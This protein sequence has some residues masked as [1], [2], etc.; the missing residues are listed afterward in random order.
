MQTPSASH[1][2]RRSDHQASERLFSLWSIALFAV[3]IV[4]VLMVLFPK[5]RIF[6]Q[7]AQASQASTASTFFL[8]NLLKA[9][10]DDADLRL[11][12]ANH[13]LELGNI[14]LSEGTLSSLLNIDNADVWLRA[15]LLKVRILEIQ[16]FAFAE[17]S[18]KRRHGMNLIG[19]QIELI[20]D[21]IPAP[22]PDV[23]VRLA[24]S[25]LQVGHG[26]VAQSIY[27]QLGRG[28]TP[29]TATW[30]AKAAELALGQRDYQSAASFYFS[31]QQQE[32]S[33]SKQREYYLAALKTLQS[34]N[35][36]QEAVQQ[37]ELHLGDL[38]ND[39]ATLFFL[40]S[41]GRAAGNG[42][43]AQKYVKDLLHANL[44]HS[45][46]LMMHASFSQPR[47]QNG[48]DFVFAPVIGDVSESVMD[49]N[50]SS[51][52]GDAF[53]PFTL[54]DLQF[55]IQAGTQKQTKIRPFDDKIYQLGYAVFLENRNLLDAFTLAQ[56]AVRQVP[57]RMEWRKRLAQVA[58]WIG[59]HPLALAQWREIAEKS[60]S[61]EAFEQILRLAPAAYDDEQVIFAFLGLGKIRS[62]STAERKNLSD[63]FERMGRPEDA[64]A[65]LTRLHRASPEQALLE[66]LAVLTQRM[67]KDMQAMEYYQELE[68][69]YGSRL[70]W[71][72]QQARG[73]SSRGYLRGAYDM[74]LSVKEHAGDEDDE[75]WEFVGHLAWVFEDD[76]AA[77]EAYRYLWNRQQLSMEG[78][79]RLIIL[80]RRTNPDEAIRIGIAGWKLYQRPKFLLEALTLLLQERKIV[81]LQETFDELLPSDET[82][83]ASNPQYWVIRAEVMWKIGKKAEAYRAYEHALVLNPGSQETRE[84]FLWFLVDQKNITSLKKY[85]NLWRKDIQSHSRLWG[86]A[87]AAY[88]ALDQP[89]QSLPFFVRQ[90]K[91]QKNDYLWLLNYADALEASSRSALAWQ[92]RQYA[93]LVVRKAFFVQSSQV[94]SP[95]LFEA[96]ARLV[97]LKDPGDQLHLLLQNARTNTT[98]MMMK[99]LVL[100]WFL[101][102]EAFDAAKS[103]LW[104]NYAQQFR[105]P[106]WAKLAL[107]L[108]ENNWV[109]IESIV[110]NHGEDLSPSDK[111]EA[112]N[113]LERSP[114][115]QELA[116]ESL[117]LQSGNDETYFKYQE[118]IDSAVNQ[119]TSRVLF[120][121]RQP[122]SRYVWNTSVSVPVGRFL[123]KPTSSVAWQESV[124]AEELTGVPRVDQRFGISLDYRL[125]HGTI[126]M[127]GFHRNALSNFFGVGLDYEHTWNNNFSSKLTIGRN[128]KADDSILLLIGGVKDFIRGQGLYY[129]TKRQFV[130]LQ[131]DAPR[132][133]SQSR[134]KLGKGL[135][136]DGAIGHHIR[137]EYPDVTVRLL[138]TVQRYSR[139][140]SVPG[141][142]GRLIPSSQGETTP[143]MVVPESFAQTGINLSLGDSIRDLYTKG[144]R[145]FGLIGVNYN[146]ATG[147]GR[148]IEAGIAARVLG[149]DRLLVY[150]SN[151]RG[152]FGQNAT[153]S[154]MNLEYQRWF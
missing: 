44:L 76:Q 61:Q 33:Q 84:A 47:R 43:F 152:G 131:I 125:S 10:P 77:G 135:G 73:L 108:A 17:G 87:A 85:L 129:F 83:L 53:H 114:I 110:L 41:L 52:E 23:L 21:H 105:G 1:A 139:A 136:V 101:S 127:T 128:Y 143:I 93:W 141:S 86:P 96:Y 24:Q 63:A 119:M 70:V 19:S 107:A 16:T 69:R 89:K 94:S 25:A 55:A 142:I 97:S 130:S 54:S 59:R 39:E 106:G 124:D 151:I 148:S 109:A 5:Q 99:E 57:H 56:A 66:H 2:H 132:F 6:N 3:G 154:R 8:E 64:I 88:V 4:L 7:V 15:Q 36:L 58:E 18:Q 26:H 123:I 150:G 60:P 144:I 113:R 121:E 98:S 49:K 116:F 115:A 102:Q 91:R 45:P 147:I 80:L 133:L 38:R 65:Y 122:L 46:Y 11:L 153:I 79:E 30:Y 12:L 68:E 40:V 13:Q 62:L 32:S 145:P 37:A 104:N 149:Q 29:H 146:S 137:K 31:A 67:G 100:A 72:M 51:N 78:Q 50:W 9:K 74:L 117:L 120:E 92:I 71:T 118:A 111:I 103:W 34:G 112:A 42:A 81:Q 35:L 126:R 82:V 75:Y 90:L 28:T 95:R 27:E 14:E 48:Q 138:G 20:L 134:E 22:E 140:R